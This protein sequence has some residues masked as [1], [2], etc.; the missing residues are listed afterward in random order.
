ME[1]YIE[2]LSRTLLTGVRQTDIAVKYVGWAVALVM[3]DTS[4]SNALGLADKLRRL[5]GTVKAPWN[6]AGVTLS[7]VVAEAAV[8]PQ[9]ENE[10]IVTHLI[11]RVDFALD[12]VRKGEGNAVVECP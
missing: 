5:A 7:A 3:P 12:D 4:G 9:Y 2:S 10:D 1:G 8:Q 11:N 6:G